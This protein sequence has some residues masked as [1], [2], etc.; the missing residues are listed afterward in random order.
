[1]VPD[2]EQIIQDRRQ[3]LAAAE[4]LQKTG[5]M[6]APDVDPLPRSD[7]EDSSQSESTLI[8][9]PTQTSGSRMT[10]HDNG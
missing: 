7:A 4:A 2:L 1:M 3:A 6:L 9:F 10:D 8:D 5:D